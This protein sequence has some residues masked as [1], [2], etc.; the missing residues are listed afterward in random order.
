LYNVPGIDARIAAVPGTI[1]IDDLRSPVLTEDQLRLMREA[2][3]NPVELTEEAVLR[4]ASERARLDNFGPSDFRERL[5]LILDE[6]ASNTNATEL[7]KSTFFNKCVACATTRL[8]VQ[9]LLERHPEIRDV[10]MASPIVVAGLPRSGT[11]HL[12]GLIGADSRLRSLPLWESNQPIPFP[13]ET[14]GPDGVDPRY[15]RTEQAWERIQQ[16]NP[17]IAP[18]HPWEPD[19]IHEDLD[20]QSPDFATYVWEWMFRMPRWRDYYLS[21]DQTPHYEYGKTLHQILSWQDGTTKRWVMK[22]PQH[23]EQLPTLM[24]VYP[25]AIVVFTHRDPVASLQSIV[26]QIA[27]AIRTREKKVDP[28][29]YLEY[30]TDRVHGLLSAY[31]RDLEVVPADQQV[32]VPFHEFVGDDIGWVERVYEAAGLP[33]TEPAR[34]EIQHYLDTHERGKYGSIDHDLRRD[35]GV[36]PEEIR[37]RFDFYFDHAPVV[38][39]AA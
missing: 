13:W 18:Y 38:V 16:I 24:R 12:I 32:H 26:T 5:R 2:D 1:L 37:R 19:H 25:D 29:W 35:F 9:D 17:M 4:A 6:V 34:S 31:V 30:W 21:H 20:L 36:D 10:P 7:I 3:E 39:E 27:Y 33:M 15:R 23:F 11:T 28:D 14:P 8:Q 22:C